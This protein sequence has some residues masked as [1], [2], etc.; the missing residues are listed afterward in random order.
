MKVLPANN[1]KW[2]VHYWAGRYP[3]RLGHLWSPGRPISVY[4]HLSYALDNGKF[5]AVT[6]DRRWNEAAF[7]QHV[8]AVA[9][10]PKPPEWLVVP[11]QP[12]DAQ[13]TV[14]LWQRWEPGLIDLGIP[15]AFAAQNGH[16]PEDIPNSASVIFLGGSDDWK[17]AHLPEFVATGKPVHVGRVNGRR[18]WQCEGAGAASCDGSGWFRG[19]QD[20][21]HILEHYLRCTAGEAEPPQGGQL[22][23][24]EEAAIADS[25]MQRM[26]DKQF[27]ALDFRSDI[28]KNIERPH[29]LSAIAYWWEYAPKHR[30]YRWAVDYEGRQFPP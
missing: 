12:F 20:Q 24:L 11:D 1:A 16:R 7:L 17:F 6:A 3:E 21:L 14:E 29:L 23:L 26:A 19:K 5:A 25:F 18:L 4:P 22:S 13:A 15:L 27:P 30:P 2:L 9:A 10:L 8:A 28:P